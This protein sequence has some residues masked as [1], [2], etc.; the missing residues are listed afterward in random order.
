MTISQN[1]PSI[2][3]SLNLDFANTKTLDPRITFTRASTAKYYDF[4]GV[5][6]TATAASHTLSKSTG[7]VSADF[8][9]ISRS[10]ATGG[11]DWYAGANSTNGGGNTGWIFTAAPSAGGG[12]FIAFFM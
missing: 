8:L 9:S 12:S 4:K 2:K 1:Y 5:M 3:P 6:Q 7:I 11:A 10:I